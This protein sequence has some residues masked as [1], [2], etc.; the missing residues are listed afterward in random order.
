MKILLVRYHDR[1]NI[2]S[3]EIKN[4]AGN[5]GIWP[6]LGLL[7]LATT[8]K[9]HGF[10]AEVLDVLARNLDSAGARNAIINS[11]ADIVGIT[12]TTPEVRGVM[13]A[14]GFAK[15]SN[16]KVVIGGPHLGIFPDETLSFPEVDFAIQ[17]DGEIPLLRLAKAL[18]CSKPDFSSVPGLVYRENGQIRKN[19]V[20]VETNLDEIVFP[21]W[22][23]V[24]IR[25]YS[26]A[27]ALRPLATT[28][29]GRGCPYKC[30]FCHRGIN[31]RKTRFR[32]PISVVDEMEYLIKNWGVREII[33]CNDTM[34]I[35]RSHIITICEEILRRDFK[36]SWQGATRVDAVDPKMLKLMR[37]AGCKQLKFG[38]ESGN[39]KILELM[40]KRI[41][42]EQARNAFRWCKAERIRTGAY[43]IIGYADENEQT[44]RDTINFSKEIDP[45]FVMFYAGIPLPDTEFH[46]LAVERKKIDP[47]YWRDYV[48]GKR[49][50]KAPYLIADMNRCIHQAFRQFYGRPAFLMKKVLN[51][52]IW[53]S[54]AKRP[55]LILG[56][57]FPRDYE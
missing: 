4:V 28:I 27:D 8:L 39:D 45:D 20:Y 51:P 11:R 31:G 22:N 26:R 41:T 42:K 35:Q 32:D 36:I 30:G 6:P 7:Y 5:M 47:H 16:A 53:L 14:A 21:D 37:K 38:I 46:D 57:F 2:N 23:F 43:F 3:R 56:L 33:F 49:N 50:D 44:I 1:G 17:G 24:D 34:T 52:Q 48:L 55:H 15:A 19:E 25:A 9:K 18:S 54:A 10:D 40:Q 13:E 12:A 29:S